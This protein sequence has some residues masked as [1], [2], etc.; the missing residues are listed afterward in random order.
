M[1]I[2]T[3]KKQ[4]QKT[5]DDL[6]NRSKQELRAYP[7][8]HMKGTKAYIRRRTLLSTYTPMEIIDLS[9]GGLGIE[10]RSK[11][12]MGEKIEIKLGPRKLQGTVS[13][14]RQELGKRNFRVGIKFDKTL[15]ISDMI[16]IGAPSE[17]VF[18]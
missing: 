1:T 15:G 3:P 12:E 7:R 16:F 11:F 17:F 2:F 9:K 6:K 5:P 13:Y 18:S 4:V 14:L 8:M 10:C